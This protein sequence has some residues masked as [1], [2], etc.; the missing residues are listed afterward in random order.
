[1]I[2]REDALRIGSGEIV[3]RGL[4]TGASRA[5][6]VDELT[7]ARPV[8]YNCPDLEDCWIVYAESPLSGIMLRSSDIILVSRTTGAVLY[9]GSAH[10][11]G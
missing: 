1:M 4:G 11:E 2:T 3:A 7:A 6:L 5:L 10:D 8:L 9:A